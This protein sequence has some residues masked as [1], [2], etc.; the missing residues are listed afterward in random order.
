[1]TAA[2][3]ASAVV[4]AGAGV[5]TAATHTSTVPLCQPGTLVGSLTTDGTHQE[6]MNHQGTLMRLTNSGKTTCT[7]SG[8]AG[9]A[10]E[11]SQ[12]AALQTTVTHGSTY[13]AADPGVHTVTLKPGASA[14][15]DLAWTHIGENT[16]NAGYLQISPTGSNSHATVAFAQPVDN[17]ALTETA[18]S[19][20]K[21]EVS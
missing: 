4:L 3:A 12:H 5:A 2:A 20:T 8:Y 6:G 14:W 11:T 7:F 10:L 9:L 15:A 21:P 19:S 18:W 17:G 13:F 1:M 16:A